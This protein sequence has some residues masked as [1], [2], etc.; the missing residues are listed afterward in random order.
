M[1]ERH[2]FHSSADDDD[3]HK[4]M[5]GGKEPATPEAFIKSFFVEKK[6]FAITNRPSATLRIRIQETQHMAFPFNPIHSFIVNEQELKVSFHH[7]CRF[8][9]K[10]AMH[11]K[12]HH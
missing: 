4:C 5:L 6:A 2:H 3:R 11:N 10:P 7:E 8:T 12:L 1:L 9:S